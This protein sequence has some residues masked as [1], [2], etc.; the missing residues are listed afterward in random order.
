MS[1]HIDYF[2][3]ISLHNLR[4]HFLRGI[5]CHMQFI[6]ASEWYL[7]YHSR[8]SFLSISGW[9][10][11]CRLANKHRIAKVIKSTSWIRYSPLLAW[12][13]PLFPTWFEVASQPRMFSIRLIKLSFYSVFLL[14]FL[15]H[16][17]TRVRSAERAPPWSRRRKFAVPHT[18]CIAR[19]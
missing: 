13:R 1:L 17:V 11:Q 15:L 4:P 9:Q 10:A 3:S 12:V 6:I 16:L 5:K 2:S 7:Q 14:I 18:R 19:L 8:R